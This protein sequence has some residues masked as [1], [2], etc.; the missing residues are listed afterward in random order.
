MK[1]ASLREYSEIT[2][3]DRSRPSPAR[4]RRM[5]ERGDIPAVR[6]GSRWFVDMD[7]L[8]ETDS[9]ADAYFRKIMSA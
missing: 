5:A 6:Q 1:L 7:K 2:Y 9:T 3:T 8:E 4:L